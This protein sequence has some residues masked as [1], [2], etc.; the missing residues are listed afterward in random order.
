[1]NKSKSIALLLSAWLAFGS[2][3]AYAAESTAPEPLSKAFDHIVIIPQNFQ[4]KAY[5]NGQMA[6][7]FSDYRIVQRE[8]RVYVP[9]R[10]MSTLASE[11]DKGQGTWQAI[12][13]PKSPDDVMLVNY[14]LKKT[15]KLKVNSTTM[16]INNEPREMDAAPQKIDGQI[17]LPLKSIA[18][19]LGKNI[20]WSD[21]LLLMGSATVDL[22]DTQSAALKDRIKTQLSDPRK[23]LEM[24]ADISPLTRYGNTTY[25]IK[26]TYTK[27]NTIEQI[28]KKTDGQKEVQIQ[29]PGKPQITSLQVL[30]GKLYY[31]TYITNNQAE[32]HALDLKTQ[33][34]QKVSSLK[35]MGPDQ[36]LFLGSVESID[37]DLFVTLNNGELT[38]GRVDLYKVEKGALKPVAGAKS[39]AGY[40]KSGD[41]LYK[42]NFNFMTDMSGNL[43]R[44]NLKTGEQKPVGQPEFAY[45]VNRMLSPDGGIGYAS[46]NTMYVKDGYLYTLGYKEADP[47][48]QSAV[49]KINPTDSTQ[50]KLT[51]P[52]S[53]FWMIGS[54]VYY[55][56]AESGYLSKTNLNG[57]TPETVVTRK[58]LNV[59]FANG[60]F[61]YT[62]NEAGKDTIPGN[63][64]QY[65]PSAGKE[66]KRS[67]K[68][69]TSFYAGKTGLYYVSNG[70][71]PGLYKVDAKGGNVR[72]VNDRIRDGFLTD[73][74]MIYKLVYKDGI[75][76]VK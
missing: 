56:D 42:A 61:Y 53:R 4:G 6:D 64:Y 1:M 12:W 26:R 7:Y 57:A 22:Q 8:G 48:D 44:V 58:M 52:A 74:G 28:F 17:M 41:Y 11:L 39:F 29:L 23:P 51:P 70:Y 36:G 49:Y 63:L 32:L 40:V 73:E 72:L 60:S 46:N 37:N 21:G 68:T 19:A 50:T 59:Q 47:N 33:K 67:D 5:I 35:P 24:S 30:N 43:A 15:I 38:L 9:I 2:V 18:E 45:G 34:S 76:F 54:E 31:A 27:N 14:E 16:K 13:Q 3:S 10:L 75:Y 69:V 71:E 20:Q 65:D 66:F 62:S 55:I 25:Y